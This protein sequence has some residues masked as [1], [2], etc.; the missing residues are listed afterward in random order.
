MEQKSKLEQMRDAK[1]A[2]EKQEL[3]Y[4]KL[5]DSCI[6][7][8][9]QKLKGV[10][11]DY[12]LSD[13]AVAEALGLKLA[14]APMAIELNTTN[15]SK[16]KRAPGF[17]KDGHCLRT[18]NQRT[19]AKSPWKEL[20]QNGTINNYRVAYSRSIDA[21]NDEWDVYYFGSNEIKPTWAVGKASKTQ[22]IDLNK[23]KL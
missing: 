3:A 13:E 11:K 18:I 17:Y 21:E 10:I 22:E 1:S 20:Y 2:L 15:E 7:E 19:L 23:F 12:D 9:I 6:E 14:E 16:V 4:Q 8:G 5:R